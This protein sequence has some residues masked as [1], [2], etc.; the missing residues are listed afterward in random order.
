MIILRDL[1]TEEMKHFTTIYQ[2]CKY[3]YKLG[4]AKQK[5]NYM[6]VKR[7]IKNGTTV[8]KHYLVYETKEPNKE[9]H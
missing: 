6:G 8:Y 3:L 2:L 7:A 1:Y 4:V 5:D 9:T